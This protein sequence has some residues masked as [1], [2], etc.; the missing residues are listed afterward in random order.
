MLWPKYIFFL[1]AGIIAQFHSN[2]QILSAEKFKRCPVKTINFEQ[3]LINNETTGIV[4]DSRGFTWVS[5]RS[6]LQRY[7]G[8]NLDIINPVIGNDTIL[9]NSPVYLFSRRNGDIWIS[10]KKGVLAYN[11][12]TNLFTKNILVPVS[13]SVFFPIVPLLETKEGVWC[14]Q[15]GKGI[16]LYNGNLKSVL[17]VNVNDINELI[18]SNDLIQKSIIAATTKYIFIRISENQLLKIN[19]VDHSTQY[20]NSYKNIIGIG[21]NEEKLFINTGQVLLSV[22]IQDENLHKTFSLAKIIKEPINFSCILPE[23]NGKLIICLNGHIHEID[24]SLTFWNELST[25]DEDPV[26]PSGNI[27]HIY[28]DAFARL[29][30]LPDNDIRIIQ[31]INVPFSHFTYKNEKSDIVRCIYYDS[32]TNT[33]LAGSIDISKGYNGGIRLF[34]STGKPL[35]P[36]PIFTSKVRNIQNIEKLKEGNFLIITSDQ[37]GWYLLKLPQKQLEK[38]R[39][40]TDMKTQFQLNTTVWPNNLQRV[41]DSTILVC[42]AINIFRCVFKNKRVQSIKPV[43]PFNGSNSNIISCFIYTSEK[44]IWAGTY[45]GTLYRLQKDGDLQT[46]SVEG[47]YIIRCFAEDASHN[48]WVGT[49]KG[50]TVF[51]STGVLIKTIDTRSGLLNDYI[52]AMLPLENTDAVF[53][54]SNL[55]LSYVP[56]TGQIKNYTKEL[57]LQ[58]NEFNTESA[59]KTSNGKFYFGGVNGITA[60]Y[61]YNL[62]DVKDRPI[63]NLTRLTINDSSYLFSSS[64]WRNDSI[65]LKYNQNHLQFDVAALG[66]LNADEYEYKYRIEN[67]EEKWH[68]TRNPTGIK[69]VLQPGYYSLEIACT[70]IFS[71]QSITKKTI[72]ITIAPPWWQTI[73]FRIIAAILSISVIALLLQ[74]YNRRKYRQKIRAFQLQQEIQHERERISRDLHDSLGAYTASIASNIDRIKI[75]NSD[76]SSET[77]LEELRSN[78]RSIVSQL[79]DTI[80]ALKKD[81]LSLTAISDRIKV[82]IQKIQ[83]SYPDVK[84]E[85]SEQIDIDQ[86]FPSS[87]AFHLLQIIQEAINN[88]LRH[89]HCNLVTIYIEGKNEWKIIITDNGKGMPTGD[90]F[91]DKGNGLSNMVS[92]ANEAGW[93]INWVKNHPTGTSVMIQP[94]TTN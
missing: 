50:I 12:S 51:T 26:V 22:G 77:A 76:L 69:Y 79:S 84:M 58:E 10:Y 40:P 62:P 9:I 55:G 56:L 7:N 13:G 47:N 39:W 37:R 65:I 86:I 3:G 66:P 8:Y 91:T 11:P 59:I 14:M 92:R 4:I 71:P 61:P 2:S 49:D 63:L 67:F 19:T 6:G 87:Q 18:K 29:W 17:K 75:P 64:T 72:A 68:T 52:Y 23:R 83:L 81:A 46:F 82:F 88:S 32:T 35:W 5:T 25:L 27:H 85:I 54:S 70:P 21:C 42:S 41:N 93:K 80:W 44:N 20:I 36:K 30:I 57:G 78:S 73:W 60:F 48:I 15:Y 16:V 45:G 94:S 53:C 74:E 38:I 1:T 43:L 89:S 24:S 33:I 34:D 31:N 90:L 28:S